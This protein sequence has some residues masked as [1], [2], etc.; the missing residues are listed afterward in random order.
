MVLKKIKINRHS[1]IFVI[2]VVLLIV[3]FIANPRFGSMRNIVSM[4]RQ[5]VPLGILTLGASFVMISGGVDLSVAA[6]IQLVP[7]FFTFGHTLYGVPGLI[8]GILFALLTGF[9]IGLI[10]GIVVTKGFVQPFLATLFMSIILVGIRYMILGSR[11]A[12]IIPAGIQNLVKGS[13][14]PVPNAIIILI[15]ISILCHVI[16]NNTVFGRNLIAVGTNKTAAIFSGVNVD[17]TTIVSYCISGVFA[18]LSAIM[19]SGYIGFAD[20]D[21]AKGYEF[22]VLLVAVLGGSRFA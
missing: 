21:L 19:V 11:P 16:L 9:I 14:G 22:D 13:V 5:A 6:T 12:G 4:L 7:M 2:L 15:A 10:N 18:V 8:A 17:F 1:G 3:G 20:G